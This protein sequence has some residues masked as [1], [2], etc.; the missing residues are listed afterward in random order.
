MGGSAPASG[1]EFQSATFAFLAAHALVDSQLN[2]FDE[3]KP[4]RTG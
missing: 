2:W 4:F 1:F 3:A